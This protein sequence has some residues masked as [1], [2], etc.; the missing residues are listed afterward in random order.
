[1]GTPSTSTEFDDVIDRAVVLEVREIEKG[2]NPT[3]ASGGVRHD[4]KPSR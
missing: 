1:V 4:R 3:G 2:E